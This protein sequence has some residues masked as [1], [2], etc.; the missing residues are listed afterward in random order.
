MKIKKIT[1][2]KSKKEIV[3]PKHSEGEYET[4]GKTFLKFTGTDGY[5]HLLEI[6]LEGKKR[7][8]VEE[9][10]RGYRF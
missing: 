7:M 6:Q 4:D 1:D 2:V 8:S 5:L 10:L 9:F 3:I